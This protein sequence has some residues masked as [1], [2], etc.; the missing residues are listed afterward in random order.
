MESP[1]MFPSDSVAAI[2]V[3][4]PADGTRT[5]GFRVFADES[6]TFSRA[7][8]RAA[9][10]RDLGASA[11]LYAS[12]E[13][14]F[15][16]G[17]F[18]FSN[19]SQV[20]QPEHVGALTLGLKSRLFA[21]RVQANVE[22]FD[23]SY[24]DQQV[25]KI[26]V[27]SRGA[28]NLRTE[29]IGQATIRG[30][31]TDIEYAVLA[32][33]RLFVTVQYL[34]A[35]YDSY[36]FLVPLS[37]GRPVSGCNLSTTS[38]G[39]LVDCAGRRSPYAPE[40]TLA[41]GGSHE[42]ALAGGARLVANARSRYQSQTLMG[43][44]FLPEQHQ[45]GYWIVDASLMLGTAG[46][47]YSVGVFGQNVTNSTVLSNTFVVPFSTFTVGALRPPRTLGARVSARF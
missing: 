19:D 17:G 44:D 29:N 46:E 22:L 2:P 28:T 3:F 15:K 5:T 12:Y 37:A 24:R 31:E 11:I 42:L 33:T 6:A 18:F 25:S 26:A 39:F 35:V 34:D 30:V 1:L 4:N 10:E 32:G 23:W 27:D 14:G 16:S 8:W 38:N 43:L 13:T 7:T 45:D 9:L 41:L 40:R 36:S 47:R 21:N 20:Y